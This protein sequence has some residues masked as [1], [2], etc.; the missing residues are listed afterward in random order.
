MN[1][2]DVDAN[3]SYDRL[4]REDEDYFP[5]GF[6]TIAAN[7]AL[8]DGYLYRYNLLT[9]A[10]NAS[11]TG[12]FRFD[13]SDNIHNR[14]QFRYLY[15]Q[16]D[17]DE[18]ET[19]GYEFAVGDV[20]S[21]GNT[22]SDNLG[23]S[24]LFE[25]TRADG[26]FAITNFDIADRYVIDALIRNDGSSLF[27]EEERRQW[28]Y[29]LAGAWLMSGESW[30]GLPGV[31]EFKLRYSLGTAGGRPT[32]A[33]QYETFSVSAGTVSPL[34][35]GNNELRPEFTTE[36]EAGLDLGFLNNRANL[37]VNYA[38][39]STE[40]QILPLPL[41]AYTGY[42]T[43]TINA[44][45]L[46]S[47]TWEVSLDGRLIDRG[48]FSWL[49]RVNF[50]RTRSTITEM[51]VPGYR[52]GASNAQGLNN[53]FYAREGEEL[54]TFYGLQFAQGCEHLP[55]GVDCS[56]FRVNSDGHLVWTNGQEL[57]AGLWGQTAP[58]ALQTVHPRL[59]GLAFGL[60]FGGLCTDRTSGERTDF[61]PLGRT[62]PDYTMS[63]S[64]TVSWGGLSVYGLFD[65]VQGFN[66]YNQPLQ[67]ATFAG[68]S[69][70]MDQTGVEESLQKPVA[71]YNSLYGASGL[72]PS[73]AFVEDGSFVKFRELSLRY[74]F[75]ERLLGNLPGISAFDGL[76]LMLTGRNL[77]TW[78]DYR[79]YD[80]EVGASGAQTGSAAL[81]RVE[82]YQ[83]P[84]FRTWT[85]G[86]EVN[87]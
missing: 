17:L 73:S 42:L 69:G 32:F 36:H 30:F 81:G 28:Y 50:D 74:T 49:A 2:F 41:P 34:T 61:C 5:A 21:F 13:L 29:R 87:F 27:G 44:G 77:K 8:N 75:G 45:T 71:Y 85:L 9:E 38:Q 3:A 60:P 6:R 70:I 68:I 7:A 15:E 86:V 25:P 57:T 1:W 65:A 76:S 80:P 12:T 54:G 35:L 84:N 31:D 79:G 23:A 78:T 4:D 72:R 37:T 39:S 58:L 24:S 11:V 22:N 59:A 26:Y 51:S 14:T 56:Q 47:K 16:T 83:Y 18:V 43:R 52:Y 40:D 63:F 48:S 82:G 46:E 53:V 19:E 67:W 55:Q 66:V 10:L 62:L 20:R 33:A 64:S